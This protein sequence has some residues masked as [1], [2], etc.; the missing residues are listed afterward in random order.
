MGLVI[1]ALVPVII[2]LVVIAA[3][4][5]RQAIETAY[6]NSLFL[7][8]LAA[9]NQ[10]RLIEGARNILVTL[11]QIPAIQH[12][13]RAACLFFL[14]NVLMQ[15]PVYAN[16]GAADRSGN[17]FC[18][19]LPQKFPL[20]I[21][22]KEYFQSSLTQGD[23]SISEIEINALNSQAMITLAYPILVGE[24]VQGVVFAELDLRW[25][26][27]FVLLASLPK[28]ANFRV[29]DREGKI[30]AYYPNGDELIGK[31][32]PERELIAYIVS[33]Q[34]GLIEARDGSGN[35]RLY[36]FTPLPAAEDTS[37]FIVV[38][39]PTEE[40]LARPTQ[41]LT[42]TILALITG[43]VLALIVAWFGSKIL[44]LRQ[45]NELVRVTRQ[46]SQGNLGV[47]AR[48]LHKGDE[49]SE[50]AKAFNEMAKTLEYR[51]S[52][53]LR[54]QEQIKRQKDRA[55]TLA[56]VA[57]RL[58]TQLELS[59]VL[60][61]ICDEVL[62][63]LQVPV[64]SILLLKRGEKSIEQYIRTQP[65]H[66]DCL[67]PIQSLPFQE[68]VTEVEDGQPLVISLHSYFDKVSSIQSL[69]VLAM[70]HEDKLIG[71]LLVFVPV[72]EMIDP[73]ELTLLQ[74]IADEAAMAI[75]NAQLYQA[76]RDEE[77]AQ[78]RL[79]SSLITAQE[80]ERKRIARELHDETSQTLTALLVGLDTLKMA[81]QLNP[82]RIEHHLQDLK[83][84]TEEMLSNIHRLIAN[85][86]PALLDDLGL[87]AA[88]TW[89][90]D[91][92]LTP[93]GIEF[94]FD[95][96]GLNDR[97]PSELETALFRIVQ[98]ALTNV[99]RHANAS[100]V[101]IR[102]LQSDSDV[103]LDIRDNGVGFDPRILQ[104]N[105]PQRG[106]GLLGMQERI[107]ILGGKFDLITAPGEGTQIRITIPL[108]FVQTNYDQ[109]KSL[110]R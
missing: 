74:G 39:V 11:S 92:R 29:H 13:D 67:P 87:I 26:Q 89:Y 72:L 108:S 9:A 31:L 30:L 34:E 99:I 104:N 93:L 88:I 14:R 84:I 15:H 69:I 54:S 43:A 10:E 95:C 36:A 56:R 2:A 32:M 47:R 37:L 51:Q 75:M 12:N 19:T 41:N 40:I 97:Y 18:M 21:A 106:L 22:D 28:G 46:L 25:L 44:I 103:I 65:H 98:E 105:K 55:E 101:K 83:T 70:R 71:Y 66:A 33:K 53:Q 91:M 80:E 35:R 42:L 62:L 82:H 3:E 79:L 60:E 76:L 8:K 61:A 1:I 81:Y 23:F 45:V 7:A 109:N 52:E 73:D 59:S 107:A 4:Q 90:G 27:Q 50:L 85:L 110:N 78:A 77:Q 86:R 96:D 20:N 38:D 94:D 102:L 16:F 64:V 57:S 6:R 100:M 24:E 68:L 17:V 48:D 63:A 49:L 5:R 58:N